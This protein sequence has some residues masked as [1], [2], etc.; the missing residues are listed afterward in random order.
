MRDTKHDFDVVAFYA[1][2]GKVDEKLKSIKV[3]H[4]VT[5]KEVQ[6]LY[7]DARAY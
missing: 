4:E 5:L 7:E 3:N 6:F 2:G 1:K